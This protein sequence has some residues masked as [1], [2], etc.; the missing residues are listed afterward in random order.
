VLHGAWFLGRVQAVPGLGPGTVQS[1]AVG[2]FVERLPEKFGTGI[3]P[4]DATLFTTLASH[5]CDTAE[6]RQAVGILPAVLLRTKRTAGVAQV[7]DLRL[8]GWWR[9]GHGDAAA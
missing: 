1:S 6:H 2:E 3:S 5:R 4:P 7:R 9:G 8:S